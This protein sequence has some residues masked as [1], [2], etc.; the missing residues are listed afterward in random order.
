MKGRISQGNIFH[1]MIPQIL[2]VFSLNW[3]KPVYQ[4]RL[5][6]R[7]LQF[8]HQHPAKPYNRIKDQ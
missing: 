8:F 5:T 3:A 1:K 7:N 4:T 6:A 2:R